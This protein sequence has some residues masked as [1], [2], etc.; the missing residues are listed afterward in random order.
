MRQHPEHLVPDVPIACFH[1]SGDRSEPGL[2]LRPESVA[3]QSAMIDEDQV[4]G[5]KTQ[6]GGL[7]HK[8]ILHALLH[9]RGSRQNP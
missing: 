8:G 6:S 7:R 9:F 1:L 5:I 2:L 3:R 4:A